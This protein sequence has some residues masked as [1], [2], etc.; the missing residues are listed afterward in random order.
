MKKWVLGS[1]LAVAALTF[2]LPTPAG[3]IDAKAPKKLSISVGPPGT[4]WSI[5]GAALCELFK[6]N[7]PGMRCSTELGG[8]VANPVTIG[9]GR[10]QYGFSMAANMPLAIAG[11]AP[12]KEKITNLRGMNL[13]TTN[14]VHVLARKETGVTAIAQLKGK[15]YSTQPV[16][17]TTTLSFQLLLATAGLAEK[18]LVI[19]R[20]GQNFGANQT[21]DRKVVGFTATTGY[22][23][24]AFIEVFQTMDVILLELPD[25]QVKK[26]QALN[27]GYF[28]HTIPANSYPNQPK[29]VRTVATTAMGI[30]ST[31]M[32]DG[33]AYW[34]IKMIHENLAR[35]R[36]IHAALRN[37]EAD[38]LPT[39]PGVQLHP[40]AEAYYK[41]KGLM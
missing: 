9:K 13:L 8:G 14:A 33:E 23:S 34:I 3:A 24:A 5:T 18:D 4:P 2:G 11:K 31:S 36:K 28:R 20:G 37:I 38:D 21:K 30:V 29:P 41:E 6:E 1:T 15:A 17:N 10:T 39:T 27:N 19:S 22:P 32:S 40:G 16:G 7:S 25:A 35:V 12:Y 26:L